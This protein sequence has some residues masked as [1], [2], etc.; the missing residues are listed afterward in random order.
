MF[1]AISSRVAHVKALW[2]IEIELDGSHL[3]LAP[4][5]ILDLEVDL[6]AVKGAA[7]LIDLIGNAL[8]LQRLAQ[9]DQ[10]L[11]PA[12]GLADGLF[13]PRGQVSDHILKAQITPQPQ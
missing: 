8:G 4:Q 9:R 11:L 7:A 3:P 5:G 12:L 2:L 13:R 1:L 6:G 10:S